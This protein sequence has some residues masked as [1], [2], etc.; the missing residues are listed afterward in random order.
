VKAKSPN[1]ELGKM[2]RWRNELAP[3]LGQMERTR[4]RLAQTAVTTRARNDLAP[5]APSLIHKDFYPAN[6]FW[7]G[8]RVWVV[9]FDELAIGDPA[10][11]VGHFLAHM[12]NM[13]LKDSG[14]SDAYAEVSAHF[15]VSYLKTTR[16]SVA[17][18]LPFYKCYTFLKL[19]AK[20]ARRKRG[21]WE[22]LMS[23][24]LDLA[25]AEADRAREEP[26]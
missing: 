15:L 23:K 10:L 12:Q 11:D 6:V 3:Y 1:H 4:L 22:S 24:L 14:T 9:D 16:L 13:S 21:D 5:W 7:D 2:T 17:G 8:S 20:E 25:C 26:V 18:R 19:A